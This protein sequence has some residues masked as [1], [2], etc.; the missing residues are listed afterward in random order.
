MVETIFCLL[1]FISCSLTYTAIFMLHLFVSLAQQKQLEF[2]LCVFR[3]TDA[4]EWISVN[5]RDKY[6]M[7][8][9]HLIILLYVFAVQQFASLSKQ[10]WCQCAYIQV[11]VGNWDCT[12]PYTRVVF[13][14]HWINSIVSNVVLY[15]FFVQCI[16]SICH[17][18]NSI[19]VVHKVIYC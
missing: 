17:C 3:H 9:D 19:F 5:S 4:C 7:F 10:Y 18:L 11:Y 16:L 8:E 2:T 12:W 15:D 6:I 1:C 14:I 13:V